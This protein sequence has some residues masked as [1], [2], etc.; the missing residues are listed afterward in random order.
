MK[1]SEHRRKMIGIQYCKPSHSYND[2]NV[3]YDKKTN[4]KG[5]VVVAIVTLTC[6]P[7]VIH[8]DIYNAK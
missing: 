2:I 6:I 5:V 3:H 1:S 7:F 8:N 4:E